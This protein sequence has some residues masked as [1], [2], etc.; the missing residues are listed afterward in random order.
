MAGT[1]AVQVHKHSLLDCDVGT[2][3]KKIMS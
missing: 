2:E 3:W 1:E